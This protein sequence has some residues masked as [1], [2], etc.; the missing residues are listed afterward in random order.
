M[1]KAF[2]AIFYF[3]EPEAF[4][5]ALEKIARDKMLITSAQ[6][7]MEDRYQE[8]MEGGQYKNLSFILVREAEL[9]ALVL[10]HK[11]GK[12]LRYNHLGISITSLAEDK[13]I[14][15]SAIEWI[16]EAA[17]KNN[18]S[19]I[20][21]DDKGSGNELSLIGAEA[22][23]YKGTPQTKLEAI[24]DLGQSEKEIHRQIRKSYKSLVNQG[25]K[26]MRFEYVAG[27][28]AERHLFDDF[29]N[30]HRQVAGRATRSQE[31]W[32]LQYDMIVT[33]QAELVLGYLE[34]HG[35]ISSAL[36]NDVGD[37]TVYSVAVYNRDLFD[38]PLAH[39]NVYEG[40]MRAKERGQKLFYLGQIPAYG[41]VEEKEFNIGKFKK[42]FCDRLKSYIE[43]HIKV[44]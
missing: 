19:E 31:T 8:A 1:S 13:K 2:T 38:Y 30:F 18:I 43:W 25:R 42:G 5:G 35:L 12:T 27:D 3:D 17:K 22:F 34:P 4:L 36:F 16:I 26:E 32:D 24:I 11:V 28:K 10:A 20:L 37:M 29:Q 6:F 7:S 14:I 33:G 15:S 23:N 44:E 41:S 39:A 21:V 40:I 9:Q